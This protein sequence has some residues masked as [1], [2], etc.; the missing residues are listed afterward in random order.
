MSQSLVSYV[1]NGSQTAVSAANHFPVGLTRSSVAAGQTL[2]I[3]GSSVQSTA[4]PA[5][6]RS[7]RCVATV[8]CWIEI[9]SNPTAAATTSFYLPAGA[10]E[11][12]TA[13]PGDE[14]AVIQ[15]SGSGSLYV[16]PVN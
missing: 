16:R 1:E 10:A 6:T 15:A 12:F 14:V 7:V 3:G 5:G 13:L 2:A 4:F 9:N 11:Y 8:D